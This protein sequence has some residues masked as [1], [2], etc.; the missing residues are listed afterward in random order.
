MS[1]FEGWG[2]GLGGWE[3][4]GG[5]GEGG[6]GGGG[7]GLRVF[8][9]SICSLPPCLFTSG[10]QEMQFR[11]AVLALNMVVVICRILHFWFLS[12]FAQLLNLRYWVGRSVFHVISEF[13]DE[14]LFFLV[15]RHRS[16]L[17]QVTWM[18]SPLGFQDSD[19]WRKGYLSTID[20]A[21]RKNM[22]CNAGDVFG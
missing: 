1:L 3:V 14:L 20:I 15:V 2:W 10:C 17:Y 12:T 9:F 18:S 7:G 13:F 4:G 11:I 19:E 8:G 5:G 6:V 21:S 16:A 22:S